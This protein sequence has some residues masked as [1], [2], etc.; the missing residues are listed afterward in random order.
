MPLAR[1]ADLDADVDNTGGEAFAARIQPRLNRHAV[2]GNLGEGRVNHFGNSAVLDQQCGGAVGV[3][4]G[5]DQA[6][7]ENFGWHQFC[8]SSAC[9]LS[10]C[11][12]AVCPLMAMDSTA[13]RT[14]MP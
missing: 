1:F 2:W 3:A 11:R 14:A 10:I 9:S 13:M 4:L 5:V 12:W 7:V 8:S 6:G